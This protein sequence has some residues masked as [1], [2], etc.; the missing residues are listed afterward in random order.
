MICYW[1]SLNV[2]GVYGCIATKQERNLYLSTP[3]QCDWIVPGTI[4]PN[5]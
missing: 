1:P 5:E 4:D 2:I 3:S